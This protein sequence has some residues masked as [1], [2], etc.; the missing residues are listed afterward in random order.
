MEIKFFVL[1]LIS[2]LQGDIKLESLSNILI[3]NK[4]IFYKF[5]HNKEATLDTMAMLS[6]TTTEILREVHK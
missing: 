4:I 6:K 3:L 5:L 2:D 1:I